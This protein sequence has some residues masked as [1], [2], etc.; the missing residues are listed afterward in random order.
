MK[1]TFSLIH[2]QAFQLCSV[3]TQNEA[4]PPNKPGMPGNELASQ[5]NHH[6]WCTMKNT[7]TVF[8]CLSCHVQGTD[9]QLGQAVQREDPKGK[10]YWI[11]RSP[12]PSLWPQIE[13]LVPQVAAEW[14]AKKLPEFAA[15][16]QPFLSEA[17]VNNF[18]IDFLSDV[19]LSTIIICGTSC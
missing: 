6:V 17:T 14:A 5:A 13:A 4:W 18:T 1:S 16:V 11:T 3:A 8:R 7:S 9:G 12:G 2:S 10:A 19:R 15:V